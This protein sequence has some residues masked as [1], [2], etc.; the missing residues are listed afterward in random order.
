M[1][2][3]DLLGGV[4]AQLARV[5]AWPGATV[6]DAAWPATV[7]TV[8]GLAIG[9]LAA[10]AGN[11]FLAIGVAPAVAGVVAIAAGLVAGAAVLERGLAA[12]C[13]RWLG[14]RWAPLVTGAAL[15]LRV[16]ALW[17]TA[18]TAWW[19]ALVVPAGLGRLAAVGLQRV[20]DTRRAVLGRSLVVGDIPTFDLGVAA[21]V[22]TII[23]GVALGGLGLATVAVAAVVAVVIGL[24]LQLGED[25]LAADSLAVV[26]VA[27]D[28]VG[29][30][31][32]AAIAPAARSP[33]IG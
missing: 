26:A 5:S 28:L 30:V 21:L 31:A 6:G 14:E 25:E 13:A 24:A 29:A 4:R 27:I 17:S 16:V 15:L 7:V 20:G 11:G 23:A 33:F 10:A 9:V 22:V 19:S 32:I 8:A 3:M 18:S 1:A 12:A 2:A